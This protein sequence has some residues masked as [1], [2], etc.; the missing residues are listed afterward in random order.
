MEHNICTVNNKKYL[1]YY[2]CVLFYANMFISHKQMR[3]KHFCLKYR[4][5][6][7]ETTIKQTSKE[8]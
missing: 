7:A 3:F 4:K 2:K 6:V 1:E 5:C 8:S